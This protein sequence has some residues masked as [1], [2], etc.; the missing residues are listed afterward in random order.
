[1]KYLFAL[2][3]SFL[4]LSE[5]NAQCY[6]RYDSVLFDSIAVV[7]DIKYGRNTNSDFRDIDLFVDIYHPHGDDAIDR[8]LLIYAHGGSFIGGDRKVAEATMICKEFAR[9]GYVA[10]S[11]QYRIESNPLSLAF[12]DIMVKAVMRASEDIRASV[13]FFRKIYEEENNPYG[14][15]PDQIFLGGASAGS[16]ACLHHVYMN[17]A[18]AELS[19]E[20]YR[21]AKQ[22]GILEND[23]QGTSGNL[24]FP[25]DVRAVINVSGALADHHMLDDNTTPLLSVH[26]INDAAVPYG[27]GKPYFIPTLPNVVGSGILHTRAEKLGI[28]SE[29]YKVL[30]NVHVPYKDGDQPAQP[31]YDST[32]TRMTEFT[33]KFLDCN[34]NRIVTGVKSE[35][36]G[37]L[38]FY[39]NPA[40]NQ[41]VIWNIPDDF[42]NGQLTIYS[43][44]GQVLLTQD[45]PGLSTSQSL[46]LSLPN[47]LYLVVIRNEEQNLFLRE[48]LLIQH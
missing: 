36:A 47:G 35:L 37:S 22:V 10:A 26:A 19:E 23:E 33:Y 13:R 41:L 18:K 20:F 32:I 45:I 34:P 29:L 6:G 14:I 44:K 24:G 5:L 39:P 28:H 42:F 43:L 31:V 25:S 48:R 30:S 17:D 1:M 9:R 3:I 15:D 7:P 46:D 27:F 40:T 2:I 16:I 11:V 38:E 12:P 8:P 21:L 4:F